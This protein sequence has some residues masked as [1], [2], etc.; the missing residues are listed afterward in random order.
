MYFFSYLEP[1]CCSMSSSN[2]ASWPAYRFLKRQVRWSGIPI[3]FRIFLVCKLPRAS[4][5][6]QR[7]KNLLA[8]WETQV[9]SLDQEEPLEK[10]VATHSSTLAWKISWMEECGR[11][12]SMGSQKVGHDWATELNWTEGPLKMHVHCPQMSKPLGKE[13]LELD[14][15]QQTGSK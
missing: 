3:S 1:V 13:Q 12:Q 5:V 11:L 2:C 6:S 8:M 15:E 7:V 14:M 4:L 9:W 10:E